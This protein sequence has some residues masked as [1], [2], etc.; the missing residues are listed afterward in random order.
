MTNVA[1][2]LYGFWSGFGIPAYVENTVPEDAQMPY[3]TYRLAQPDWRE[4]MS[5][6]ARVWY[7]STSFVDIA[8]KVDEISKALATGYSAKID[9]GYIVLMK[10]VFFCQYMPDDSGDGAIKTAY[11]SLIMH[12]EV[13]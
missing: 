11:L 12:A 13:D 8:A 6:Y 9:N 10:D 3:I 2:A 1:T 5:M 4:P 7:R